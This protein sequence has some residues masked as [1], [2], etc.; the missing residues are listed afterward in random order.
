MI[1]L[2]T[3][4]WTPAGGPIDWLGFFDNNVQVADPAA[5]T[6]IDGFEAFEFD[7]TSLLEDWLSGSNSVFALAITVKNDS[8][9]TDFLHGFLSNSENP[10]S[11]FLTVQQVPEPSSVLLLLCVGIGVTWWIAHPPRHAHRIQSTLPLLEG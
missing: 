9:G 3:L 1:P 8:A 7:V 2:E 11:N 4:P 5:L 6:V 10:G